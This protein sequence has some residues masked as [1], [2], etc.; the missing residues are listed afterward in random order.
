MVALSSGLIGPRKV[1]AAWKF[2]SFQE[3]IN[4]NATEAL[5]TF[6]T[7]TFVTAEKESA[8]HFYV[9]G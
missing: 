9:L 2:N 8:L 4:Q 1:L 7:K 3:E 5:K 6:I